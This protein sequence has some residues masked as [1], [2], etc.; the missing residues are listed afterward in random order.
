MPTRTGYQP[1]TLQRADLR[2]GNVVALTTRAQ[3]ILGE[4]ELRV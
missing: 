3:P 1:G 4:T 2:A